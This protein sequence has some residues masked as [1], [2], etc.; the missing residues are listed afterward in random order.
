MLSLAAEATGEVMAPLRR[1]PHQ[2]VTQ[3]QWLVARLCGHLP[4][5]RIGDLRSQCKPGS[6]SPSDEKERKNNFDPGVI[7]RSASSPEDHVL[8]SGGKLKM[9]LQIVR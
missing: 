4:E 6:F 5:A 1:L 9:S 2:A 7:E 3:E 8:A